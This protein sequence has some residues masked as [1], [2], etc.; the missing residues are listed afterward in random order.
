MY[1]TPSK[2]NLINGIIALPGTALVIIPAI[3][4]LIFDY[5]TYIDGHYSI[6]GIIP[7]IIGLYLATITTKMFF[8]KGKGTPAPWDPPIELV[9][10]GIYARVRNPM[11]TGVILI[12]IG[13]SIILN[14]LSLLLWAAVFFVGNHL[15]FIFSEEPK[16]EKRF[17]KKYTEYRKRVPRWVPKIF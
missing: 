1:M 17:G 11:I 12:I 5:N 16:L 8:I 2:M 4:I 7:L 6:L 14:S 15:Y 10:T 13:E 3:I 9:T